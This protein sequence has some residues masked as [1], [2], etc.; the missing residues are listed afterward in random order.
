MLIFD[1]VSF[2]KDTATIEKEVT[3]IRHMEGDFDVKII[4]IF[5]FHYP[6]ALPPFLREFQF[7]YVTSIG[8]DNEKTIA[9]NYG[10]NN[11]KLVI[12]FKK[13]RKKAMLRGDQSAVAISSA[14]VRLLTRRF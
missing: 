9:D 2:L 10:K 5:N 4:L 8:T 6:K 11:V 13:M 3:E 7:K 14:S 1:D 12:D